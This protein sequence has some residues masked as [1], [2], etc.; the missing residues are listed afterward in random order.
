MHAR[1]KTDDSTM[2]FKASNSSNIQR[3]KFQ[4]V[5]EQWYF[6]LC[7]NRWKVEFQVT[8]VCGILHEKN[9]TR[10]MSFVGGILCYGYGSTCWESARLLRLRNLNYRNVFSQ[11]ITYIYLHKQK[12]TNKGSCNEVYLILR[13][14]EA[15]FFRY[16]ENA[17][18]NVNQQGQQTSKVFIKPCSRAKPGQN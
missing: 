2:Y 11:S 7:L 13:D 14:A 10:K 17:C 16:V 1:H 18:G 15:Q 6:P 9:R 5:H 8:F 4:L 12:E 3:Y